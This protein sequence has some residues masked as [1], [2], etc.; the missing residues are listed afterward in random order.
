MS[1]TDEESKT[2][3]VEYR[4]PGAAEDFEHISRTFFPG[5]ENP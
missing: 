5:G 3:G 2:T 4:I 1:V